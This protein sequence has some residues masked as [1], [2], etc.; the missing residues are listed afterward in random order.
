MSQHEPPIGCT[1]R[2]SRAGAIRPGRTGEVLVD[3]RGGVEAYL[4][5]DADGGSIA[6]G[7]EVVVVE[8]I[9]PRTVL[10]TRLYGDSNAPIEEPA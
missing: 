8:K 4:A 10:V 6:P 9:G 5:R 7:E 1:G 3:V 2:I